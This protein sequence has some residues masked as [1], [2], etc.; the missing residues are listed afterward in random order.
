MLTHSPKPSEIQRSQRLVFR[1]LCRNIRWLSILLTI[2]SSLTAQG[3][4]LVYIDDASTE[5]IDVVIADGKKAGETI[6]WLSNDKELISLR[7]T[8]SDSSIGYEDGVIGLTTEADG[9]TW[10]L[11]KSFLPN[12]DFDPGFAAKSFQDSKTGASGVS[13][14]VN[15]RAGKKVK[16]KS[17][18]QIWGTQTFE[19]AFSP[20]ILSADASGV[21]SKGLKDSRILFTGAI[22]P[23][24]YEFS[25]SN[26]FAGSPTFTR[27]KDGL[28]GFSYANSVGISLDPSSMYS[29]TAGISLALMSGDALRSHFDVQAVVPEPASMV[30][31]GV[32]GVTLLGFQRHRKQVRTIRSC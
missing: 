28:D 15:V 24:G 17:K 4:L 25:T 26:G 29:V 12:F 19:N 8:L 18:L 21:S 13:L 7:T 16:G 1:P 10:A 20:G 14:D 6:D 22:D 23:A 2:V 31:W 9:G 3:G 5:G 32:A 30:L 27:G 11:L